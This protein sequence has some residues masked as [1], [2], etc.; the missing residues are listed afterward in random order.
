METERIKALEKK[1]GVTF[2]S[3][4]VDFLKD[5]GSAVVDGFKVAGIPTDDLPKQD[6]DVMDVKKTTDLLRWKRSD[7]PENL[8]AISFI[9][10]TAVCLDLSQN[11]T[12]DA[13][14]VE[15]DLESNTPPVPTGKTFSQWLEHHTKWEKRFRRAWT[16]CRNRQAEAKGTFKQS[17]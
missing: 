17:L 7:L 14:L 1:L 15:V 6:R 3:V 13:P 2:P 12:E 4:Y 9:Q 11:P 8:V 16:R 10:N 5:Q